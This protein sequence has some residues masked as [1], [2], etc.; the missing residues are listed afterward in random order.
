MNF[1]ILEILVMLETIN[2]ETMALHKELRDL[3]KAEQPEIVKQADFDFSMFKDTTCRLLTEL[4]N[5]PGHMLSHKIIRQDVM[6]DVEASDSAVR[7]VVKRARKEMKENGAC[8]YEIK[9]ICTKGYKLE[10]I[11]KVSKCIKTPKSL[12]KSEKYDT[13]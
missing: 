2:A 5:A 10:K 9:T 1:R 3:L 8:R 11:K 4:L 12:P 6:F 13:V 7:N